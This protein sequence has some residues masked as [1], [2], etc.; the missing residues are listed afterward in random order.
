[1]TGRLDTLEKSGLVRR[2]RAAGDRRRVEVELTEEG[3]RRWT[4][5][6]RWRGI[7]EAELIEPLDD[8]DRAALATLLKRMLLRAET[9]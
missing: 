4:E 5:A 1:M 8:T 2:L 7:A 6:M 9:R 3:H